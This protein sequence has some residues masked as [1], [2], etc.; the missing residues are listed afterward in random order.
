M[1]TNRGA[2]GRVTSRARGM[3]LVELM[4]V[5]VIVS[6]GV[7]AALASF[8]AANKVAEIDDFANQIRDVLNQARR[9]AVATRAQLLDPTNTNQTGLVLVDIRAHQVAWCKATSNAQTTCPSPP[10]A[11]VEASRTYYSDPEVQVVNWAKVVD[12]G[13]APP[14]IALPAQLYFFADGTAD[15]DLGTPTIKDGFTLYLQGV[16][17]LN[18]KRKLFVYPMGGRPRITDSW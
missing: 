14:K 8:R 5:V 16:T 4:I 6:I 18:K 9:R 7:T 2:R 17:D 13:Q 3:T 11:G 1:S 10:A 15:S 12:S